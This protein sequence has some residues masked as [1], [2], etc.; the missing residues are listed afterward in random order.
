MFDMG[1]CAAK[2]IEDCES[3]WFCKTWGR[4]TPLEGA[5]V[6]MSD[7]DCKGGIRS[8]S[9]GLW[10]FED[11]KCVRSDEA[12]HENGYFSSAC[13]WDGRCTAVGEECIVAT[14]EDCAQSLNCKYN[15]L[16]SA[17]A[18]AC[19]AKDEADCAKAEHC[20][21]CV[22]CDGKCQEACPRG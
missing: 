10:K 13:A 18:K 19:I 5:C 22:P 12:C 20:K 11:G 3:S 2:N 14:D 21:A 8:A 17:K 6:P 9:K 15:G 16:C 1:E 7:E 4:C